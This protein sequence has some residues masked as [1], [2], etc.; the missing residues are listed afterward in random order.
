MCKMV[1]VSDRRVVG[2][3]I[4]LPACECQE[5]IQVGGGI[6]RYL[7]VFQNV[8]YGFLNVLFRSSLRECG[9]RGCGDPR[10]AVVALSIL[11]G[12]DLLVL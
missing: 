11:E 7:F 2:V 3:A 10:F 6:T 5:C 9:V 1:S 4:I 12:P 8:Y